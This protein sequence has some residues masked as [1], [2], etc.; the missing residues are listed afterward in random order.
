MAMKTIQKGI[1]YTEGLGRE[2]LGK[3]SKLV[4]LPKTSFL[5]GGAVANT[6]LSMEWG[7][8]YP[9]NDLDIFRIES[10][11]GLESKIMPRRCAGMELAGRYWGIIVINKFGRSYTVSKTEI[12]GILNFVNVQLETDHQKMENYKII[13]EGFDLNCCQVGIDL[14]SAELIYSPN[15]VAFL[16]TLQLEVSHPCTPFHT[17]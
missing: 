14:E 3:L 7:G 4:D 1:L 9:I 5:A 8:D 2:I 12:K 15:F 13:L 6:I 11:D 10:T 16:K 17:A